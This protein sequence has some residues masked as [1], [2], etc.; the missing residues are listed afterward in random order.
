VLLPYFRSPV[1][2]LIF[3]NCVTSLNSGEL[4]TPM[5]RNGRRN[6]LKIRW[7]VKG[8]CRFESGHRHPLKCNFTRKNRSHKRFINIAN[9]CARKRTKTRSIRQLFVK[10]PK[11]RSR[12][13]GAI[14]ADSLP[15][16]AN[17][18]RRE[19]LKTFRHLAAPLC[20]PRLFPPRS[21]SLARHTAHAATE[22]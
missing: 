1:A 22:R 9:G 18:L 10:C 15:R 21:V 7:A 8:P 14:F 3:A 4:T 20:S 19:D 12:R 11:R 5:W 13:K 2:K 6:G 16:S 17:P